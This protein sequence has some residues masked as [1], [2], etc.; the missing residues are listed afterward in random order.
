MAL[1]YKVLDIINLD[2]INLNKF[3]LELLDFLY[4]KLKLLFHNEFK[5]G[6]P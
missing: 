5:V 4:L 6:I 3:L 2:N 1:C